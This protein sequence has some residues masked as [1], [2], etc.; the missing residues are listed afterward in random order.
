MT[1][2]INKIVEILKE[3]TDF[4]GQDEDIRYPMQI[5]LELNELIERARSV[6]SKFDGS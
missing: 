3:I 5:A 2:N 4:L 1:R 6:L